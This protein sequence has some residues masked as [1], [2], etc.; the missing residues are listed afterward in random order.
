M[1]P[2]GLLFVGHPNSALA[3]SLFDGKFDYSV[4]VQVSLKSSTVSEK[5]SLKDLNWLLTPSLRSP[6][7][8]LTRSLKVVGPL[9]LFPP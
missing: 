7:D 3:W 8:S 6:N 4:L 5:F 9:S 2:V 1:T